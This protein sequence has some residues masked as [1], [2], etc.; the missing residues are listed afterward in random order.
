M[1]QKDSG[2][3]NVVPLEVPAHEELVEEVVVVAAGAA[4]AGVVGTVSELSAMQHA[5]VP[6]HTPL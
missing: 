3:V 2:F 5:W 1:L 6:G 4:V